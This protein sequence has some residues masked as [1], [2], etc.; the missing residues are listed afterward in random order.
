MYPVEKNPVWEKSWTGATSY[1]RFNDCASIDL[2]TCLLGESQR[3]VPA[4]ARD[5]AGVSLYPTSD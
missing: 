4:A 5:R 3:N 2:L 1:I